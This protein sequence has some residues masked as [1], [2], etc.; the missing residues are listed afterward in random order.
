[1]Y[2]V[3]KILRVTTRIIELENITSRDI[4]GANGIRNGQ[5]KHVNIEI[6]LKRTRKKKR[7]KEKEGQKECRRQGGKVQ[8]YS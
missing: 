8:M 6:T 1:M 7:N 3:I 4:E 2:V 5:I